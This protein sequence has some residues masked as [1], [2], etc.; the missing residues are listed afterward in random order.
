MTRGGK[1]I[2]TPHQGVVKPAARPCGT[3]F[4]EFVF[5]AKSSPNALTEA[6][7]IGKVLRGRTVPI[8]FGSAPDIAGALFLPVCLFIVGTATHL[9]Q[10]FVGEM[11]V[12]C[13][14]F[15]FSSANCIMLGKSNVRIT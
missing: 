1:W 14:T 15:V 5:G 8:N 6:P 9:V 13:V 12:W 2:R 4:I 3:V 7:R 10:K 11:I